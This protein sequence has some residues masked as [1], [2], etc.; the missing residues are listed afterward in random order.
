MNNIGSILTNK[1]IA[2]PLCFVGG[3][4]L[5]HVTV[6]TNRLS[7]K[8]GL[9]F[10]LLEGKE[11]HEYS[12]DLVENNRDYAESIDIELD[13]Q[14]GAIL[15]DFTMG[16]IREEISYRFLLERVVL[17]AISSQFAA[18]SMARTAV[19]S[20]LFAAVHLHNPGSKQVLTVQFFNTALVGIVCSIAQEKFGL[21]A[22]ICIHAGFNLHAWKHMFNQN[23]SD[24]VQ[25]LRAVKRIDVVHPSKIEWFFGN[26]LDDA[27]SPFILTYKAA[28]KT[29]SAFKS[30]NNASP[31]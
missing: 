12:A 18:F 22:S 4:A 24:V 28:S 3:Y 8:I 21:P 30:F 15:S 25:K 19:S 27:L 26:F 14:L 7:V 1:Y 17:P 6:A 20:L 10:D 13:R 31:T 5:N 2:L 29:A 23:F 16:S 9:P 11:Y